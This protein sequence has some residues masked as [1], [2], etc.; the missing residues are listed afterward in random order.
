MHDTKLHHYFVDTN[1]N[2]EEAMSRLLSEVAKERGIK[3]FLVSYTD[4][5][6]NMRA[7]L[8]PARAIDK[9]AK[10]GAGLQVS[11]LGST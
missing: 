1:K 5:F 3:N 4:L 2:S 7:K 8:V 6:G 11:Q 10:D 9:M